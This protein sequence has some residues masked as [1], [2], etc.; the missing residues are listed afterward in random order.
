[1]LITVSVLCS[2]SG[3]LCLKSCVSSLDLFILR[4][5]AFLTAVVG[6]LA[7]NPRKKIESYYLPFTNLINPAVWAGRPGWSAVWEVELDS[8][9]RN[10]INSCYLV[11]RL[12]FRESKYCLKHKFNRSSKELIVSNSAAKHQ[13]WQEKLLFPLAFYHS[14]LLMSLLSLTFFLLIKRMHE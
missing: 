12:S 11:Q 1:M 13:C 3:C 10:N 6:K 4:S 9:C 5:G 7:W 8:C 2:R 14:K